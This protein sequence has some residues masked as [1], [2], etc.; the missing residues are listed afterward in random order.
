MV[1]VRS[2]A[3]SFAHVCAGYQVVQVQ[4]VFT[5][6]KHDWLNLFG[7]READVPTHLAYIE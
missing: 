7:K 3:C 4:V 6:K 5:L 2:I 1:C